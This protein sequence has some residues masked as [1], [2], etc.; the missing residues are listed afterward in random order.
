M[1]IKLSLTGHLGTAPADLLVDV[2]P[3]ATVGEL[4]DY[5]ALADPS[6]RRRDGDGHT[7]ALVDHGRTQVPPGTRLTE[8]GVRSGTSV[9]IVGGK[10]PDGTAGGAVSAAVVEILEGPDAG[11]QFPL[12]AGTSLIGRDQTCEVRL[13]DPLVSRQHARVHVS[14]VVEIVD[15]GSSNGLQVGEELAD[16]VI[17]RA[18]DR[19]RLGD[20]T[21]TAQLLVP[22]HQA[23]VPTA[24]VAFNRP[25]HAES[26][27]TGVEMASPEPPELPRSQRFPI[28]PLF[29]PL[30]IG[31]VIYFSTHSLASLLFVGM[32]PVLIVANAVEGRLA[33]KKGYAAALAQFRADLEDLAKEAGAAQDIEGQRRREEH[34][35]TSQLADAALQLTGLLWSRWPD[36]PGFGELRLGLGSQPSRNRIEIPHGKR[37]NRAVWAELLA[38]IAP[39]AKVD[40]VPIVGRLSDDGALGIG[41]ADED[42]L[43][44]A[45]ALV[46]QGACLHS[47][48]EF[49]TAVCT[50]APG[51]A[52][53]D[54]V[55]WLPHCLSPRSPLIAPP[56]AASAAGC[57]ALIADLERL[58][59]ERSRDGSPKNDADSR[60]PVV[61]VVLT[62]DAPV[63]RSRAV[64]IARHGGA[65]GVH[66]LWV[67]A[68]LANLPAA[69][70][71]YLDLPSGAAGFVHVGEVVSPLEVETMTEEAAGRVARA[72]SA[73]VD[74]AARDDDQAD[75]PKAV[76]L[77]A[78]AG[79]DLGGAAEAVI[80]RWTE[81][82]SI[83][84][85]PCASAVEGVSR[86]G[87]LRALVGQSAAG[88]HVLD[89]R[90]HGPHA[91][92]GGT[93]GSGKSE[94]LQ[95]WIIG[96]A[97][98]NSPQRV[99]FLLVD[100]KGGSAFSECVHLPH[101]I[102]LVTDLSPHLVRRALV[103]LSAELRYR[104][105]I[106]RR[107]RVKDLLE[108]ERLKDPE[109]P[110]SLV[111]VVDEF[112]ALVHEVPEF[113]DG[114]VNV[115]QRGR[116]LGLHLILA[117]QRPAGVIKDNLRANTNL[118]L[119]LRMADEADST[120]VL[121]S[122]EAASFDAAVPGRAVSRTGPGQ[123]VPFQ[124]AYVGGWTGDRP[125]QAGIA[126]ET[127]GFGVPTAWRVPDDDTVGDQ[128]GP[129]DIQRVVRN[130]GAASELAEI[131][132][133]RRPWLPELAPAYDLARLP[134]ARTDDLL[135]FAVG[136][137]ADRQRQPT[138]SFSP[139][140][141]G[142]LAI[143]G[144][145]NSGK[146][147]ALRSLAIAAGF[148][149]RGGPCHV[150]GLDFGARGL[151]MLED[152]P[153]V[154]SIVVGTDQERV[155][156]LL[157]MLRALIDDRAPRYGSVDA[158][159]ITAYRR[160]AGKPDEARILLLVDGVGAF[161]S[162][163]EGTEHSR[164]WEIFLGIAA[165][166]RPAGIHVLLSA[167]RPGALPSSL[168]SLVQRRLVLRLA[169]SNDYSMLGLPNDVVGTGSPP[170]RGLLD[171]GEVQVAVLGGSADVVEQG[172]A[173]REL[174]RSMRKAGV[175]EAAR[176]ER[177]SES[178]RQGDLPLELDGSP[179]L[180]LSGV[181]LEPVSFE[182]RGTFSV[183]GP[184][185]SGRTTAVAAVVLALRRWRTETRLFYIG[186]RRSP[187]AASI[188][189]ERTA[190]DAD[191]VVA[192][193][194]EL[195]SMAGEANPEMPLCVLVIEH[196]A[197]LLGGPA[198]FALQEPIKRFLAAGHFLIS[199][200]DASALSSSYP[201]LVAARSGRSGVAL[202][203]D[204]VDGTLFRAQFPR[205]RKA[206]FPPGRGLYVPRGGHPFTV[207]VAQP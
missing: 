44:A 12:S 69:C 178:V 132:P 105:E 181:T 128:V 145:G 78:L 18:G 162:A 53:W 135:V 149:V 114:V 52:R 115:A 146:S 173:V 206:D 189:W 112:A 85:G 37:N 205:L 172:K 92:V 43:A 67:A 161:R 100:Y 118:R 10:V 148:T 47:P 207:Q 160:Q 124:A 136:D 68:D 106:L 174:G 25:P 97:L 192:L 144:T 119:A 5:L 58:I 186:N 48:A 14:D 142:N 180:G 179:V 150:Y 108:L 73:V 184:P 204:Q 34:P 111:I 19:V 29:A 196:I 152:L 90:T 202:Q 200:G 65:V 95:S 127:L 163:Y 134:T 80:E 103:S 8:S 199:E 140:Q 3:A 96:M 156:R 79:P 139:D 165:D 39:Y 166:G 169:D 190:L 26:R 201:L 33:G 76:S 56:L 45:R 59:R 117:T 168:A 143:Y 13:T 141:D 151:Q 6:G 126:V 75:L 125:P 81:S 51:G 138:V 175:L 170:G 133:P 70:R 99:T 183:A 94:L 61:L 155:T 83:L 122:P 129:T 31:V 131:P 147:A 120:D 198:D 88:R 185:G 187:L 110:P 137:D 195:P 167:D 24:T 98:A 82:Q 101:T 15:F 1:R 2:D 74:A 54:W 109:A 4:A 28:L 21:L 46:V 158:D 171:S 62:D 20:T 38:A 40:R 71:T 77:L 107:K 159:S 113:V 30:L 23:H 35:S 50:S 41:G 36:L 72:L 116:S 176:I 188:P 57:D 66:V 32:S 11:R 49:V 154:G 17:L 121:G 86:P 182:P 84:T 89:L 91:L 104:E 27:Y 191:E 64:A 197:D 157:G 102:G 22:A 42:A 177:L 87:T 193:A 7:L 123:L 16:R 153:H 55:K 203:P 63:D 93:T 60:L 164:W 130:I 194:A 9:A